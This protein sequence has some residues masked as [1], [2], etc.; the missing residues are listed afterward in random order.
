MEETPPTRQNRHL[1]LERVIKPGVVPPCEHMPVVEGKE[2][3]QNESIPADDKEQPRIIAEDEIVK[4]YAW[5]W[6]N[7]SASPYQRVV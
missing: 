7:S 1:V 2:T 3:P 4:L 5:G 6:R